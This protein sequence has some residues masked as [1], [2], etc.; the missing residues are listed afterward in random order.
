MTDQKKDA[1]AISREFNKA[2]Q[3][4]SE[5]YVRKYYKAPDMDPE[6]LKAIKRKL[7]RNVYRRMVKIAA[8][9]MVIIIGGVS[10]G[11]W[12]NA[13]GA[14]G[15]ERFISKCVSVLSPLDVKQET[16]EDGGLMET[17]TITDEKKIET[18]QSFAEYLYVPGYIPKGHTFERLKIYK[19]EDFITQEYTY[20]KN[21][22]KLVISADINRTG[23]DTD[24]MV[25]GKLYKSPVTGEKMY[26]ATYEKGEYSVARI[27]DDANCYIGGT[28]NVKEGVKVMEHFKMLSP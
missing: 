12:T 27:T 20:R 6:L 3:E 21:K 5:L 23:V 22:E 9:F 13:D 7:H 15:G 11:I 16:M 24:T 10:V 1:Q 26:V 8:I 18:A 25:R 2:M 4:A 19:D 17:V 14:Y 28:G